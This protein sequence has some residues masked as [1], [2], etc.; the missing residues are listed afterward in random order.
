[1]GKKRRY[2]TNPK[3]FGK[4][5]FEI[6]DNM[7]GTDD[8]IIGLSSVPATIRTLN[9][10]DNGDRT[11]KI[12]AEFFGSGSY[13]QA[14]GYSFEVTGG[15][16]VLASINGYESMAISSSATGYRYNSALPAL[17]D[18][19]NNI[20][21]L[22]TGTVEVKALVS[23]SAGN[24]NPGMQTDHSL[25]VVSFVESVNVG[26]ASI[27]LTSTQLS[28][29]LSGTVGGSNAYGLYLSQMSGTGPQHG[30][31]S[32]VGS[33][34]N[35]LPTGSNTA[36]LKHGFTISASGSVSGSL[37]VSSGSVNNGHSHTDAIEIFS[38][39]Y[40]AT[41]GSQEVTITFTPKDVN[42]NA[43]SDQ[44]VSYTQT[45]S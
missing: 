34:E 30:S 28:G 25:A 7:D 40:A 8:N 23:S 41:I 24:A 18:G 17:V 6:L 16:A 36:P 37:H 5:H 15:A 39:S 22:P 42:N 44:A 1:M 13:I 26:P 19:S 12:N 2:L 4:K 21:V 35:Y 33:S 29:A 45:W 38:A 27:G 10:V 20:M 31:G 43:S 9:L 11:V 3:K 14:M 32:G